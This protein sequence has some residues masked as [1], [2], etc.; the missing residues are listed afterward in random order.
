M[1]GRISTSLH[2]GP[3]TVHRWPFS[4]A[5]IFY[6]LALI[7]ALQVVCSAA[8]TERPRTNVFYVAALGISDV[9]RSLLGVFREYSIP[10][11][12]LLSN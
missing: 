3:A 5:L 1:S 7:S 10:P 8:M 12:D 4:L 11:A 9:G 6:S 2:R